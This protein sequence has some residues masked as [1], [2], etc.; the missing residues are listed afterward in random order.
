MKTNKLRTWFGLLEKLKTKL[1]TWFGLFQKPNKTG[2]DKPHQESHLEERIYTSEDIKKQPRDL[3]GVLFSS[4]QIMKAFWSDID[5]ALDNV[6]YG[7]NDLPLRSIL[8]DIIKRFV[9]LIYLVPASENHHSSFPGG[10]FIHSLKAA[11]QAAQFAKNVRLPNATYAQTF[12]KQCLIR[13]T[14]FTG[15]LAHDLGKLKDLTIT[16]EK[17]QKWQPELYDFETWSTKSQSQKIRLTWNK[18]RIHKEHE[19]YSYALFLKYLLTKDLQE[20]LENTE[21]PI[22]KLIKD[23]LVDKTG[24]LKEVLDAAEHKVVQKEMLDRCVTD[25]ADCVRGI[26]APQSVFYVE[27]L[28]Q[29]Q[30]QEKISI[31]LADSDIYCTRS[32]PLLV[33][34]EQIVEKIRSYMLY[35]GLTCAPSTVEG[36]IDCLSTAKAITPFS[37]EDDGRIAY[38]WPVDI[39]IEKGRIRRVKAL[40]FGRWDTLFPWGEYPQRLRSW[41]TEE[42]RFDPNN[43]E[44]ELKKVSDLDFRAKPALTKKVVEKTADLSIAEKAKN[45]CKEALSELLKARDGSTSIFRLK[46]IPSTESYLVFSSEDLEQFLRDHSISRKSFEVFLALGDAKDKIRFDSEKNLICFLEK[47]RD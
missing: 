29:L 47:N 35:R 16:N 14:A 6:P 32:G 30:T 46:E 8:L 36:V 1:S 13:F 21:I 41:I 22:L 33:L 11:A 18:D 43:P 19:N 3:S 34:S 10:L 2:A 38:V 9:Q 4:E 24:P 23:C 20:L 26:T 31:N 39:E 42:Y 40:R 27:A 12:N 7:E 25:A 45:D 5:Y 37:W 15:E 17:G 28:R 44:K